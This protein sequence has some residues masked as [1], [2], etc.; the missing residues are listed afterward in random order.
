MGQE[1]HPVVVIFRQSSGY[2]GLLFW[3]EFFFFV[4][5][6]FCKIRPSLIRTLLLLS[7]LFSNVMYV[8]QFL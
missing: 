1:G 3:K 5:F 7:Y 6:L 2:N 8:F 4:F